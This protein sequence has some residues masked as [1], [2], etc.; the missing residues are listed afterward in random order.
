[1]RLTR[2][3]PIVVVGSG[4]AGCTASLYL[5]RANL[6]TVM[7]TGPKE[8]GQLVTT[9]CVEN[10]PG[11]LAISGP[12]LMRKIVSQTQKAGSAVQKDTIRSV[13]LSQEPFLLVG[14]EAYL[15]WSVIIA[16]GSS[17]KQLKATNESAGD[18]MSYCAVCDGMF[19]F[20]KG[21]LVIGGGN[22]AATNVLYLTKIVREVTLVHRQTKLRAE[23]HLQTRTLELEEASN[24]G[25]RWTWAAE[26]FGIGGSNLRGIT[27]TS[28]PKGISLTSQLEGAFVSIGHEPNTRIFGSYLASDSE[29]YLLTGSVRKPTTGTNVKGIFAAG[30]VRDKHHNQIVT[31]AA[32]GCISALEAQRAL[33]GKQ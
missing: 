23:L 31:S 25:I 32:A 6:P 3:W 13:E 8:G 33:V 5:A 22:S 1:M 20:G 29:G 2:R 28:I 4:P 30:D 19:C 24:L 18:V 7:L 14:S 27:S 12:K 11:E 15:C 17:P 21:V 10:W 9:D 16:T 26:G